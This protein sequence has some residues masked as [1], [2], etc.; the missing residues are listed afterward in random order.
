MASFDL[1]A[2][3]LIA[4]VP[5]EIRTRGQ[6]EYLLLEPV[7]QNIRSQSISQNGLV[8]LGAFGNPPPIVLQVLNVI[9]C[10]YNE[11]LKSHQWKNVQPAIRVSGFVEKLKEKFSS[12]TVHTVPSN[13][14]HKAPWFNT[15]TTMNV[16]SDLS[17]LVQMAQDYL[18]LQESYKEPALL[19]WIGLQDQLKAVEKQKRIYERA[20]QGMPEEVK[21]ARA[22]PHDEAAD[23]TQPSK[24]E[25]H[26]E[27][28]VKKAGVTKAGV[29]KAGIKKAGVKKAGVKKAGKK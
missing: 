29:T 14:D 13:S 10:L 16:S 5:E 22:A 27:A 1:Q 18:R 9:L 4:S 24:P 21:K 3:A 12:S 11:K 20:M 26:P 28:G 17:H 8:Q 7:R 2:Q 19:A 25:S 15:A 23:H 6:T